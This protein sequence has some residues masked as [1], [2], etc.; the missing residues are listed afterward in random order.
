M[1]KKSTKVT[2]GNKDDFSKKL[3]KSL[4]DTIVKTYYNV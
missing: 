3:H 1:K 2:G 4:N